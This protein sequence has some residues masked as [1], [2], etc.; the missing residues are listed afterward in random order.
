MAKRKCGSC[1]YWRDCGVA[2]SGWCFHP[3]RDELRD[4]VLVRKDELAC[5]NAWDRDL[6]EPADDRPAPVM[7][8]GRLVM[9][10]IS[11]VH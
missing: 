5:R 11:G 10:S 4:L 7:A 2:G 8:T 6:W 1:R 9:E 3:E